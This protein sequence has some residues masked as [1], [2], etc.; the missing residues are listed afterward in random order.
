M[1]QI[2][3]KYSNNKLVEITGLPVGFI[4][5]YRK[6]IFRNAIMNQLGIQIELKVKQYQ[7]NL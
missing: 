7:N 1:K 3:R 2:L 4:S 6:R 5:G